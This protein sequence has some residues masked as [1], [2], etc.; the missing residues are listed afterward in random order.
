MKDA[1]IFLISILVHD[2]FLWLRAYLKVIRL[3]NLGFDHFED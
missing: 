3:L 2:V 1:L